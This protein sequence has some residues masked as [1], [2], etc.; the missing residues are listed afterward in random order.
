MGDSDKVLIVGCGNRPKPGAVNLDMIPL[1]GVDIVYD[2]NLL[3]KQ[4][5]FVTGMHAM[6]ASRGAGYT[7]HHLP[8]DRDTFDRIEA[9]DVLEHVDDLVTVVEELGRVLKPGGV[10]W[11]RGPHCNYPEQVWADPTHKRAFAPR[12]FDNFDPETYDGQ[13]Y[14]HYFGK[15][16]FRVIER[17]EV[18][19]GMEFTLVK[20][21]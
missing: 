8:F 20:R 16:K 18:N 7:K 1:P 17:K 19:K 12:S 15:I 9:E 5:K 3:G 10:L 4:L 2:L 14:G 21:A 13:R 11:I 6:M